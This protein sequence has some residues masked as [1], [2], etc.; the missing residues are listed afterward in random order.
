MRRLWSS[1]CNDDICFCD[2]MYSPRL[3]G[4]ETLLVPET[5]LRMTSY[6]SW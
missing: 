4:T 2:W 3:P 1:V 6:S 5:G